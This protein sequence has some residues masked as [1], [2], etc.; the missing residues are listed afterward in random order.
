MVGLDFEKYAKFLT[1]EKGLNSLNV[2]FDENGANINVS[3]SN[4][5][6]QSPEKDVMSYY[7]TPR[8]YNS[9]GNIF[10]V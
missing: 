6:R 7:I 5:P 4:R 1:P 8:L 2:N 3:F 9:I 10:Q